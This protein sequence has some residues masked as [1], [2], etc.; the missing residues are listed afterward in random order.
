MF[1][2]TIARTNR[3][4]KESAVGKSRLT[5]IVVRTVAIGMATYAFSGDKIVTVQACQSCGTIGGSYAC[6][7]VPSGAYNCQAD[8][9]GCLEWNYGCGGGGC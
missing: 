5:G 8:A 2:P 3:L 6:I 9:N 4:N 1:A 7:F